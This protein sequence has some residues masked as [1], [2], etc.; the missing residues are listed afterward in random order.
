MSAEPELNVNIVRKFRPF[1]SQ[2]NDKIKEIISK[3]A[4]HKLPADRILFNYGDRDDWTIYLLSGSIE[5]AY[6]DGDIQLIEA[7]SESALNSIA[8]QIP[9]IATATSQTDISIIAIERSLLQIILDHDDGGIEVA[10]I[11]D[12]SDSDWMSRFLQSNAFL[13]LPAA[14]IQALMM[15]LK[16]EKLAA[17]CV[18]IKENSPNDDKF[19]IIQEGSCLVTKTNPLTAQT[20][21]LAQLNYGT[22]FG[23]EALITGGVRS[24]N[25]IMDTDG[26]VMVLE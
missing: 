4:V 21:N 10:G 14:N 26:I 5:L 20:M 1:D 13:Q 9:R 24:A 15:R 18:V 6:P 16:E 19:Y 2:S 3:S 17:G 7:D 25:V 23:E 22:G 12:D 8:N 11:D